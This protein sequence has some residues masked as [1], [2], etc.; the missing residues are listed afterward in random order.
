M[1]P[2]VRLL[3][4]QAGRDQNRRPHYAV[5]GGAGPKMKRRQVLQQSVWL[6]PWA[7]AGALGAAPAERGQSVAWP[8]V[9]LLDGSR[10][11]PAQ[12]KGQVVVVV[13]WSTTCP[14]CKRH[15]QHVEKLHR[16]AA[17]QALKVLGVARER[18]AAAV[19]RYAAQQG[20]SFPV[21]LESEPLAAA[22]SARK[23]IPLTAVVDRR[24]LLQQ[25]YPGEMFEEDLMEFL[26]LA[27]A[28]PRA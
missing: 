27:K 12:A 6:A 19:R 13:F 8:D 2:G 15:N 5:V 17:G 26:Q 25:V 28:A 23:V 18:D 10:F 22:I 7:G 9:A 20:Y 14:F 1:R 24:G 4:A 11:G 21:T 3:D 16:S